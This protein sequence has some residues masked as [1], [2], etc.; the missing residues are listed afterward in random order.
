MTI[1]AAETPESPTSTVNWAAQLD[2]YD[3]GLSSEQESH[4]SALHRSSVVVDMVSR[5]A[6]SA[7]FDAFQG[8]Y[9]EQLASLIAEVHR[10]PDRLSQV[11]NWPFEVELAGGPPLLRTCLQDS[12]LTCGTYEPTLAL[13]ADL[14]D[15]FAWD[16]D[17]AIVRFSAL[18][19]VIHAKELSDVRRAKSA[20]SVAFFSY[21]QPLYP[22]PHDLDAFDHAFARGLRSYM[23]TYNHMDHLGAGCLEPIDCG[24]SAFGK[25][26]VQRCNDLGVIVDLSHCG[27]ATTLDACRASRQPVTAS[28]T[29]ASSVFDHPRAKSDEALRAVADTG[30][31]VGIYAV[32]AFLTNASS[33]TINW[34]L[35]HIEYVV[36]LVG[37]EHV[38]I[39]T[40]WPWAIPGELG[41]TLAKIDHK[42]LAFK[43]QDESGR[44]ARLTGYRDCRDLPNITRGLVG[45]GFSDEQVQ[46]IL[47]EN[48]LRVFG[49]VC[50]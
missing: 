15:C 16:W 46:G 42:R 44:A 6:G 5:G 20:G 21:F 23:L 30:G 2:A 32:P 36:D 28:H 33:P 11:M 26:V 49:T 47:G 1:Q 50:G 40:D 24:L 3:F 13:P 37:W 4:A 48:F 31:V 18:P 14:T 41:S 8:A 34:M 29:S 12:G 35:D 43:P 38:G 22:S 9:R 19:W 10:H 17:E 27:E 25:K 45:R 7:I 39:G